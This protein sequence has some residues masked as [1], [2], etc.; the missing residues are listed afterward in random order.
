MSQETKSAK[1]NIWKDIIEAVILA[2]ILAAVIRIWL[3]EP[4]FIP[5]PSMEPTLNTND[6][7][8]VNKIAY[9]FHSPE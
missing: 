8:I 4:F 6:R 1:E 9:K 2:I 3:F 5:S 7:I